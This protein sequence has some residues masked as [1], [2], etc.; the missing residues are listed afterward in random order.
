MPSYRK[1]HIKSKIH[2]VKQK[3]SIVKKKW[4]WF[5]VL[6]IAF[7][8]SALYFL[9]FYP[10]VQVSNIII[11]GNQKV[12]TDSLKNLVLTNSNTSLIEFGI[13]KLSTNS[14]FFANID[15]INEEILKSFPG[16]EKTEANKEFPKTIILKLA[17]RKPMGVYCTN[18]NFACFFID[19]NGVIFES[20]NV[21]AENFM[22]VKQLISDSNLYIG[23]EAVNSNISMI[24]SKI[25]KNLQDNFQINLYEALVSS[26][27]RLDVTT[28]EGWK[29]YFNID[30]NSNIDS[31]LLKLDLLLKEEISPKSR[32]ALQYIDLRFKDRAFYK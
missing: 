24:I 27:N 5:L 17:E 21:P 16:I 29:I 30:S 31:Q 26:P 7:L 14:I 20:V 11:S 23:E 9:L 10:G 18:G 25:Q 4:V 28:I 22:L 2:R 1:K 12:K 13:F 8:S 19:E 6:F 32:G 3:K 15:K